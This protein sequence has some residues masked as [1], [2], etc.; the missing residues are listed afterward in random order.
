M[1]RSDHLALPTIFNIL[2]ND[3]KVVVALVDAANLYN[4]I[5]HHAPT[6]DKEKHKELCHRRLDE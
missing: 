4:I 1:S 3:L 2:N 6:L 5:Y